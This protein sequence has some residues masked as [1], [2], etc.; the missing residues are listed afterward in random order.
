MRI[1][2]LDELTDVW[3]DGSKDT[4]LESAKALGED[5]DGGSS[6]E[7]SGV[8]GIEFTL[9][10]KLKNPGRNFEASGQSESGNSSSSSSSEK[11]SGDK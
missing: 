1:M 3:I 7:D 10:A 9:T 5:S 4:K 11:S 8:V 6:S 2:D